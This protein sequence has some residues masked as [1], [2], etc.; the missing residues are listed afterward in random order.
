MAGDFCKFF[1]GIMLKY[2]LKSNKKRIFY[3]EIKMSK[4]KNIKLI[5]LTSNGFIV[6]NHGNRVVIIA[7]RG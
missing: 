5:S 7:R 1:D 3:R 2:V 4:D 6:L